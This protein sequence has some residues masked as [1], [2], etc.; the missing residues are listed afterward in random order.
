MARLLTVVNER[1]KARNEYRK[2]LEDLYIAE[3]KAAEDTQLQADLEARRE[4]GEKTPLTPLELKEMLK[5]RTEKKV[6]KINHI[7][8]E[9][10]EK[11]ESDSAEVAPLLDEADITFVAQSQV[12][13]SQREI[14][15]M[16]VKNHGDLS[17]K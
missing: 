7:K 2:H 1:K 10:I 6:Q 13:L 15:R 8:E 9:L 4:N 16:H 14:L 3:C 12:K 11:F 5:A 17:L